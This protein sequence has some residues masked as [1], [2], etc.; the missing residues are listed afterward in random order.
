[1]NDRRMISRRITDTT[2]FLLLSL[3]QQAL[4]F[5]LILH[6]DDDGAVE[7]FTVLRSIGATEEDLRVLADKGFAII[8]NDDLV[9]Y[10]PDWLEHNAIRPD[11]KKDSMYKNLILQ[12]VPEAVLKP[13]KANDGQV[14]DKRQTN[15]GISKV[16]LSKDKVSKNNNS[17]PAPQDAKPADSGKWKVPEVKPEPPKK[18]ISLEDA[19][20]NTPEGYAVIKEAYKGYVRRYYSGIKI[21][22]RDIRNW[23]D[24]RKEGYDF[25]PTGEE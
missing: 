8:L 14:T 19:D 10:I 9:T 17:A 15:G 2:K 23:W 25:I 6:A 13:S 12:V 11:R 3:P 4:Y 18:Q 21:T 5:H 20:I 16:K 24:L 22:D 1:M 7:A